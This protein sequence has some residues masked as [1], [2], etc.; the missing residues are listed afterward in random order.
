MNKKRWFSLI[1]TFGF[2][3]LVLW[4]WYT[5]VYQY[6]DSQIHD[7]TS[8]ISQ[9]EQKK[10]LIPAL[11]YQVDGLRQSNDQ[12]RQKVQLSIINLPAVDPYLFLEQVLSSIDSADMQ[13]VTLLPQKFKR[14]VFYEKCFFGFK[15]LGTYDQLMQVLD[16]FCEKYPHSVFKKVAITRSQDKLL[17]DALM[18][19]YV[20]DRDGL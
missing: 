3:F 8:V 9:L 20:V 15:A 12:L 1:L 10:S 17:L 14:K 11:R 18:A 4:W 5:A 6:L 2:L 16:H 19:L 7:K 13:L